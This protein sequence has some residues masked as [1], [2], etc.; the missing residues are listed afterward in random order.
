MFNF[1]GWLIHKNEERI[2]LLILWRETPFPLERCS[3]RIT[4]NTL[5]IVT[6]QCLGE[7]FISLRLHTQYMHSVH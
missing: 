2:D 3:R 7:K 5:R 4:T 1:W 6:A